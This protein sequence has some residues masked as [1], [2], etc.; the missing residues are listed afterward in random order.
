V[1]VYVCVCVYVLPAANNC[2][3]LGT[4][5]AIQRYKLDLNSVHNDEEE[6]DTHNEEVSQFG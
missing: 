6:S 4:S 5:R 1:Y 3:G 2:L